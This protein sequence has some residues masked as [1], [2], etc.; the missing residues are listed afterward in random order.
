MGPGYF[1]NGGHFITLVEID[2]D[3]Q[4]TVADVGSRRRSQFKYALKDV[5]GE[6]K[7]AGAGGPFWIVRSNKNTDVI[8]EKRFLSYQKESKRSKRRKN[9]IIKKKL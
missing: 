1:T 6:S 9:T 5:I 7:A 2:Q 3:D 4:V 8:K